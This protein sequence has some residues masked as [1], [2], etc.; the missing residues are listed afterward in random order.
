MIPCSY[1]YSRRGHSIRDWLYPSIRIFYYF[2]NLFYGRRARR[3]AHVAPPSPSRRGGEIRRPSPPPARSPR[4]PARPSAAASPPL[5]VGCRT[6]RP[7]TAGRYTATG[8]PWLRTAC[9]TGCSGSPNVETISPR[10][11][12]PTTFTGSSPTFARPWG[13]IAGMT[14]R[15]PARH[16]A[17]LVAEAGLGLARD[18]VEDLLGAVGVGGRWSPGCDL[19]VDDGGVRRPRSG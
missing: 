14:A 5:V 6:P 9:P 11:K 12:K 15:S 7:T 3:A 4:A 8:S 16:A 19:E 1:S 2:M 13:T 17:A 18:D 10:Q